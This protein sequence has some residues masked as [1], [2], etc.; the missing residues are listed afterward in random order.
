MWAGWAGGGHKPDQWLST[1]EANAVSHNPPPPHPPPQI[2]IPQGHGDLCDI[3]TGIVFPLGSIKFRGA[4]IS[5]PGDIHSTLVFRY[6]ADYMV[7]K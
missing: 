3:P 2:S 5:A 1:Y 4:V 6:G 7:P